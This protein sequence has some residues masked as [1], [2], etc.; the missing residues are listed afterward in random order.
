MIFF[1]S[2]IANKLMPE[3]KHAGRVPSSVNLPESV[4]IFT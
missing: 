2:G 1:K 4:L 3:G